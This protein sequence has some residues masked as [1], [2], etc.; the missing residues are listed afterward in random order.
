MWIGI[1]AIIFSSIGF[2]ITDIFLKKI[3]AAKNQLPILILRSSITSVCI[4]IGIVAVLLFDRQSS[5]LPLQQINW[6]K[7]LLLGF[8]Y[9]SFSFAGLYFFMQALKHKH[10]SETVG[11]NKISIILGLII[12]VCFFKETFSGQKIASVLFVLAGVALIEYRLLSKQHAQMAAGKGLMFVVAARICWAI[13]F[14]AVPQIEA[15]GILG[16]SLLQELTVLFWSGI[17]FILQRI[18]AQQITQEVKKNGGILITIGILGALIQIALN[19]SL[20]EVPI[21][22]LPFLNLLTPILILILARS[23]LKERIKPIQLLGIV[24]GVSGGLIYIL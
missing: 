7:Q 2:G 13:G 22:L 6:Y 14:M 9:S 8:I 3:T 21:V 4:L 17:L 10:I 19:I 20:T 1:I 16:F 23:Y 5:F 15:M 12:G 11:L 24:L 18:P